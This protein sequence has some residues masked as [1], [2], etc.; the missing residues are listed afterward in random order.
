M[1]DNASLAL[2][3]SRSALGGLAQRLVQDGVVNESVMH[4]ALQQSGEKK[5]SLVTQLVTSGGVKARDIA[6]AAANEYGV[7]IFDLDALMVDMEAIRTV[8]DKLLAKHRVLPLFKRGK[9]L[10][11]GVSDPT[12]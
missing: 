11:L 12:N 10:F 5:T 6:I 2:Q 9:R 4:T 3:P 8:T 7:P 1:N